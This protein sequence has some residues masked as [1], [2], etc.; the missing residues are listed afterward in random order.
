ML[1]EAHSEVKGILTGC[2]RSCTYIGFVPSF[3]EPVMHSTKR[4][5][6]GASGFIGAALAVRR[7]PKSCCLYAGDPFQRGASEHLYPFELLRQSG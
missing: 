6:H 1:H 7:F 5:K 3:I 2:K 4:S